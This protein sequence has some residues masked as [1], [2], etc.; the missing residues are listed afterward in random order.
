MA[1]TWMQFLQAL[2]KVSSSKQ[3][4]HLISCTFPSLRA[5]VRREMVRLI[6]E[7]KVK[8]TEAEKGRAARLYSVV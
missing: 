1:N 4:D 7:G 2:L 8:V 5:L 6:E 3:K